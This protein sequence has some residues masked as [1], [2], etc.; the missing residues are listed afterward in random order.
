MPASADSAI[1]LVEHRHHHVEALDR[2]ARL[3]R[4]RSLQEALE[5]LDLR[6][7]IEKLGGIDGIGR[8]AETPALRRLTEPLPLFRHEHMRVVV[9][10][11][12][13]IDPAQSLDRV[14]GACH[15]IKWAGDQ[16]RGQRRQV[17]VGDAVRGGEQ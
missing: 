11:R 4:K 5:R 17:V 15:A 16:A 8:R 1:D 7:A 12:R 9:A 10:G 2:E 13:A 6:Q 14:V 3:A